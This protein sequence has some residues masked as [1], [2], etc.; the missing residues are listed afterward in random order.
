MARIYQINASGGGVP[1][2]PV[3]SG[4]IDDSGLVGDDQADKIHHGHPWQALCLYSLE[5][6]EKMQAEGH[7]IA[8]GSAG[9]NLTISGLDWS[10][11]GEGDRLRIGDAVTIE[12]THP[13]APCSKNAQWFIDGNF[14]RMSESRHPGEA[15]L[16]ASVI[17]VGPISTGDVVEL[18][19]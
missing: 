14:L 12:I 3:E 8:P 2:L 1:K 19:P 6:I 4:V 15:R 18:L 7:P 13:A 16:Y 10:S 5:V 11:L 9:E 17:E